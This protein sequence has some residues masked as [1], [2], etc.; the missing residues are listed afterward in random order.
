M[1]YSNFTR[2]EELWEQFGLAITSATP[3]YP[4][5]QRLRCPLDSLIFSKQTYATIGHATAGG[6]VL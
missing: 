1:P 3:L 5:R 2:I 4:T 6:S